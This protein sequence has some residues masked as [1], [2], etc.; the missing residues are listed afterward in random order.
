MLATFCV[1]G[2]VGVAGGR[3]TAGGEDRGGGSGAGVASRERP[4]LKQTCSNLTI[5]RSC[6]VL[7][8]CP[9]QCQTTSPK[10]AEGQGELRVAREE[11]AEA[12]NKVNCLQQEVQMLEA[13]QKGTEEELVGV[14]D[15]LMAAQED[16]AVAMERLR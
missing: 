15:A 4:A 12:R 13:S 6:L 11:A 5:C 16:S 3:A 8:F 9:T 10:L 14:R 2:G 7:D 1:D